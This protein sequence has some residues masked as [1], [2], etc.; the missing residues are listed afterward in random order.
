MPASRREDQC[1]GR[2]PTPR[3]WGC[4]D[5]SGESGSQAEA[6][7]QERFEFWGSSERPCASQK[8]RPRPSGGLGPLVSM[9]ETTESREGHVA[10]GIGYA[11]TA[12]NRRALKP[13]VA[14]VGAVV[15]AGKTVDE[16]LAIL[17]ASSAPGTE[18]APARSAPATGPTA[19]SGPTGSIG[20][21]STAIADGERRRCS[22]VG[23]RYLSLGASTWKPSSKELS[24]R[25]RSYVT[26][27]SSSGAISWAAAR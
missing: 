14:L 26:T 17:S 5:A 18:P 10:H 6:G 11:D 16:I 8:L 13:L 4:Y 7:L 23:P 25:R 22:A 3:T 19:I 21:K 27:A 1:V 2:G 20:G 15:A 24:A 9:M 12:A